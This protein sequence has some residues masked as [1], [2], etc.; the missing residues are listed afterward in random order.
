MDYRVATAT[1]AEILPL[2]K[3]ASVYPGLLPSKKRFCFSN[4]CE[5][6][7]VARDDR[8]LKADR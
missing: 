4:D 6:L 8:A 5:L 7:S 3:K 1:T 2:N